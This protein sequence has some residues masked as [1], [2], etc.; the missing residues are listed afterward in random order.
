MNSNPVIYM[1]TKINLTNIYEIPLISQFKDNPEISYLLTCVLIL[2]SITFNT[3]Y[4]LTAK[5]NFSFKLSFADHVGKKRGPDNNMMRRSLFIIV[6]S[7]PIIQ[8]V[9]L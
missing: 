3:V 8:V 9:L 7:L 4:A 2:K 6:N 5:L 1:C